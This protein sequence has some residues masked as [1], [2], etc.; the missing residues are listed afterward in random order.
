MPEGAVSQHEALQ[1]ESD[2][3]VYYRHR[4]VSVKCSW[5]KQ[6]GY[7]FPCAVLLSCCATFPCFG[8]ETLP[9]P[10]QAR[11]EECFVTQNIVNCKEP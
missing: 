6:D 9:K 5:S 11:S 7:V 1:I 8:H 3:T 2:F 10:L 4:H